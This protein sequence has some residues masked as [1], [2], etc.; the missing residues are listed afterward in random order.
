MVIALSHCAIII[1]NHET[2]GEWDMKDKILFII[3]SMCII[4][5]GCSNGVSQEEYDK[6]VT[7]NENLKNELNE[8][9]ENDWY[10]I[11]K[12]SLSEKAESTKEQIENDYNGAISYIENNISENEQDSYISY[13]NSLYDNSIKSI[14]Y[15]VGDYIE[16]GEDLGNSMDDENVVQNNIETLFSSCSLIS[17]VDTSFTVKVRELLPDYDES[18]NGFK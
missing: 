18:Y 3:F 15:A 9:K 2:K 11:G 1:E 8:L 4:L 12:E 5:S 13:V 7:E 10:D 14:D 6:I 17:T 16:F